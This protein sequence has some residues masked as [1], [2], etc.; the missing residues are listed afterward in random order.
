MTIGVTSYSY[1]SLVK[2]GKLEFTSI[3]SK[4]KE[5]GFEYVEF[6]HLSPP[7]GLSLADYAKLLREKCDDAGIPVRAYCVGAD[8]LKESE[9][10]E[11]VRNLKKQVEAARILGAQ[12]MRHDTTGGFPKNYEE[13]AR[14]F[15]NALPGIAEGCR[16]VTEYAAEFGIRTMTENHGYFAQESARIEAIVGAVNHKNFGCLI[17]LGNFIC[18]DDNPIEA[19]GRL[20][21]YA[22]HVHVKDFHVK[23]GCELNPGE[24]FFMSRG[25]NYLRGAIIGQGALPLLSELRALKTAGYDGGYT[26]EFEGMEDALKGVRIGR[27]NLIRLLAAAFLRNN[28]IMTDYIF[29]KNTGR[30]GCRFKN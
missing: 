26:V 29:E 20:A 19:V 18:A 25:G 9:S 13:G 23:S 27:D 30:S 5:M 3:P 28:E 17:D 15:Y 12:F 16:E 2:A 22:F 4:A 24:G 10:G 6:T 7:S 11:T 21:P 14:T 1:Q 8:F